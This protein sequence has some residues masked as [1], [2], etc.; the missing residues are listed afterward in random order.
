M[1]TTEVDERDPGRRGV[2]RRQ[3]APTSTTRSH[4][5]GPAADPAGR[6]ADVG[7]DVRSVRRP[8]R[9][10]TGSSPSISRVTAE[11]PI[12]IDRS[13]SGS[14]PT[15]SR[16]SSTTSGSTNRTWSATRSVAESRSSR[17]CGSTRTRWAS[18][19]WPRR[20]SGATRSPRDARP[21]RAGELRVGRVPKG[22]ADV[23]VLPGGRTA[24][25]G[26]RATAG[27]DRASRWRRTSTSRGGPRPQG[28]D[29]MIVAADA[30]MAPPSRYVEFFKLLDG[31]LAMVAGWAR[32]DRRAGMH[33]RSC[34]V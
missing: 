27:Q 15:T 6:R 11:P 31:G 13:T 32:A 10:I 5:S 9:R 1:T 21:A 20:T 22:H 7:R 24:P 14:W 16:R 17:P 12:S 30:D 19:S 28:P 34:R 23:S 2:R 18:S 33:W 26:L 8:S 4:G 25:G 29:A 3:R